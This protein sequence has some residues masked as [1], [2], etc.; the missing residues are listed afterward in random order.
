MKKILTAIL[1]AIVAISSIGGVYAATHPKTNTANQPLIPE[2]VIFPQQA[3]SVIQQTECPYCKN[4][5]ENEYYELVDF[6]APDKTVYTMDDIYEI[7]LLDTDGVSRAFYQQID[8]DG[9]GASMTI[10]NKET[11]ET[12][13]YEYEYTYIMVGGE[14]LRCES[15][16]FFDFHTEKNEVLTN[17]FY[18][19][20]AI[21]MTPDD[22]C[23]QHTF[24]FTLAD[25]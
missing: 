12:E 21:V 11:G 7:S 24:T 16:I 4:Q 1:V 10:R 17:G 19:A 6:K 3:L 9:T 20:L 8:F 23:I 18:T 13:K 2:D 14:K 25:E 22:Q 15:S 5:L